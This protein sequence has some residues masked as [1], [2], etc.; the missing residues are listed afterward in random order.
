MILT[1]FNSSYASSDLDELEEGSVFFRTV[2]GS[3]YE[4]ECFFEKN[5][6]Y[7]ENGNQRLGFWFESKGVVFELWEVDAWH[8]IKV[9]Q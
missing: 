5:G 7:D 8:P 4:G 3:T 1:E 2:D 6:G 9:E